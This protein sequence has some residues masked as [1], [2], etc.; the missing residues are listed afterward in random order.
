M[1]PEMF[2][3]QSGKMTWHLV[4]VQLLQ[5]FMEGDL[6]KTSVEGYA[7]PGAVMQK[8]KGRWW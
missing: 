1:V 6:G 5:N 7:F 3:Q 2:Q 8:F 4:M